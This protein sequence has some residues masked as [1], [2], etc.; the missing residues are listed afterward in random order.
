MS[1]FFLSPHSFIIVTLLQNVWNTKEKK[2]FYQSG[3]CKEIS[4]KMMF[5]FD[6]LF[7]LTYYLFFLLCSK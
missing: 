6:T 3:S 4:T 2:S 1:Y 5:N 7:L